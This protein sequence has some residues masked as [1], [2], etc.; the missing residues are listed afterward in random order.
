MLECHG[1]VS[2]N[3]DYNE[4]VKK[5][6]KSKAAAYQIKKKNKDKLE[7]KDLTGANDFK[8][9]LEEVMTKYGN[10][11]NKEDAIHRFVLERDTSNDN[12]NDNNL[13]DEIYITNV[14]SNQEVKVTYTK[15]MGTEDDIIPS[16]RVR[17]YKRPDNGENV[18]TIDDNDDDV[19]VV[20]DDDDDD[21]E[22]KLCL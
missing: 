6:K 21:C 10:Y 14:C 2:M 22:T 20:D 15:F 12:N 11:R 9:L 3:E 16:T 19:V 17:L 13:N 5:Y 1:Y 7:F 18:I 8:S 4:T